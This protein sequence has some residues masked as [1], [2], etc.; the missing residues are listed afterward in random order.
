MGI[1]RR[2]F[3]KNSSIL[4]TAFVVG[5]NIPIKGKAAAILKNNIL[6]PNAFVQIDKDN[7]ITFIL[8]QAEM[9]QGAYSG[10]A[11]CIADELDA[12]WDEI[13]F[14]AAPVAPVYNKP[15][16]T[17]MITG[18]SG[19]I[20]YHQEN[21][22]KVGAVIRLMLKKAAAK[23]WKV[24]LSDISTKDSYVTNT[25]TNEKFAYGDLVDDIQKMKLPNDVKLKNPKEYRLMGKPLKRHPIEV[26]EKITGKGIFGIDVRLENQKYAALIHPQ[27]FGAKIKSYDDSVAKTMAGVLKIKQLPNNTIAVIAEHWWQAKQAVDTIVVQWDTGEFVKTSTADLKKEYRSYFEKDIHSM[28]KDGDTKKAIHN[29]SHVVEAEY[30]FPFLAHAPMEPINCTVY[31]D[32]DKALLV[33]GSQMQNLSRDKCAQ[34]LEIEPQKI[35]YHNT[36]LG[37]SFGRRGAVNFDFI[38]DASYVAK[39]EPWPVM[40][41]WTRED[42][43]K[44]AN[45][46]P[47]A[48][49]RA[50]MAVDNDGNITAFESDIVNQS[51]TQ[52]T[53]FEKFMFKNGIDKTQRE[54]LENHPYKVTSHNLRAFCPQ[55]P[56]PVLWLRSVGH[57]ISAPIV[58]NI[59]DQ[60][61]VASKIDPMDFRIK[62][63]QDA[64]FINLLK[65]VAKQSNWYKRE[66]NSGYGVAIAKSFGSIVAY[67]VKVKLKEKDFKVEKVW[68]A[69]DCGYSFN[70]LNVENQIISSVNFTLGYVKY[71]EITI[72]DGAAEQNN[73]Y[74]Y[75]VARISDAPDSINVEIIN[76]GEKIG[77]IGEPGV[78]PMFAAV[79]NALY[80]VTGK[81][82]TSFPI[83]LG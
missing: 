27:V 31:H 73:F 14:K 18:G 74:D 28:R 4:T 36:Y 54:G 23:R 76:S 47:M 53:I 46:R 70:P 65:N 5:F 6:E 45:Y 13:V 8:G 33:V 37:S 72:K 57:T 3:I 69:V 22:R 38:I 63:L 40:T 1:T 29:A 59:I 20:R 81:R 9:G 7:S 82:Y 24:S 19:T 16:S 10:L 39:N 67:V 2:D 64:R 79:I 26:Q 60:A 66:K 49:S 48:V 50:K 75:N 12:K 35:E 17:I 58:E 55:S 52:G 32:K 51:I 44:M 34:I 83:K 41:L 78:P 77:G 11:Q 62:N 61:A 43:I 80:D 68:C 21:V 71:A 15:G 42:D 25:K 30:Y 56:I